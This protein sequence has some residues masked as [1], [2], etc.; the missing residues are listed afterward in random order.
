M[1]AQSARR[2]SWRLA[3]SKGMAGSARAAATAAS[4]S[5]VT[6]SYHNS[7][8][9]LWAPGCEESNGR[10]AARQKKGAGPGRAAPS[11]SRGAP[12]GQPTL[13]V[14]RRLAVALCTPTDL[15]V[16]DE[17]ER[18]PDDDFRLHFETLA[19]PDPDE[20]QLVKGLPR[21]RATI[22][23]GCGLPGVTVP[24]A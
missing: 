5:G 22:A 2:S 9:V 1:A 10:E 12:V 6:G 19:R 7:R 18:G 8:V 23:I 15:L 24:L 11:G 17:N 3:S 13:D 16:F 20:R 21:S 14:L 4:S